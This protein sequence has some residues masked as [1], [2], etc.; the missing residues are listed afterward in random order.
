MAK[1]TKYDR[2]ERLEKRLCPIHGVVWINI[3]WTQ[4]QL[5][6]LVKCSRKDCEVKG[7]QTNPDSEVTLLDEHAHLIE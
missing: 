5:M 6:A 4:N 2:R 1:Q 7:Y 3:G